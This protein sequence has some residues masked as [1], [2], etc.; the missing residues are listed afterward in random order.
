MIAYASIQ[1]WTLPKI[2]ISL[3]W[4]KMW[5]T[6]GTLWLLHISTWRGSENWHL[7]QKIIRAY[8]RYHTFF[9]CGSFLKNVILLSV[10]CNLCYPLDNI[11]GIRHYEIDKVNVILLKLYIYVQKNP[12]PLFNKK[13]EIPRPAYLR[14][15]IWFPWWR[16]IKERT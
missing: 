1:R 2:Y 11:K 12:N 3:Y 6:S 7:L 4:S 9:P 15:A 13:I 5:A 8:R 10:L 16:K 14:L